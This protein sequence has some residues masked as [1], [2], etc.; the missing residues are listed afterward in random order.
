MTHDISVVSIEENVL[1]EIV[2]T[3]MGTL[4]EDRIH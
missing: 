3:E 2:L 4:D 1:L